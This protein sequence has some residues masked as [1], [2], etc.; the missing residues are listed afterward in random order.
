MVANVVRKG[1]NATTDF[2]KDIIKCHNSEIQDLFYKASDH[3][4]QV[5]VLVH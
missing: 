4:V 5:P 2:T 1:M 3:L